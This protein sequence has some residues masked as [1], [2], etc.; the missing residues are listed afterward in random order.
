MW[1]A[2]LPRPSPELAKVM[3][4]HRFGLVWLAL[5]SGT[6]A[7]TIWRAA[8]AEEALDDVA[9]RGRE[10][11][12]RYRDTIYPPGAAEATA[13][14]ANQAYA[15]FLLHRAEAEIEDANRRLAAMLRPLVQEGYWIT[16]KES[17]D[18]LYWQ[19]TM[20]IKLLLDPATR[21]RLSDENA[22]LIKSL[23]W[24]FVVGFSDTYR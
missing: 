18:R 16:T 21:P 6:R 2:C 1:Y 19:Q 20:L 12:L 7:G 11:L 13:I 5:L 9:R 24:N 3:T 15:V 14:G 23:L 8:A 17:D 10:I 4:R 22:E